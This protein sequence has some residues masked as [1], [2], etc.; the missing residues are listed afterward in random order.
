MVQGVRSQVPVLNGYSMQERDPFSAPRELANQAEQRSIEISEQNKSMID[1]VLGELE[2]EIGDDF[3][4]VFIAPGLEVAETTQAVALE[5]LSNSSKAIQTSR[6]IVE[7][8]EVAKSADS[9]TQFIPPPTRAAA[10][11]ALKK[12]RL[13]EMSERVPKK[14][15]KAKQSDPDPRVDILSGSTE[16]PAKEVNSIASLKEFLAPPKRA[17]ATSALEKMRLQEKDEDADSELSFSSSESDFEPSSVGSETESEASDSEPILE[18]ASRVK[19]AIQT[20]TKQSSPKPQRVHSAIEQ[21]REYL[22]SKDYRYTDGTPCIHK[23][24]TELG[25][26][27]GT[28][29]KM[30]ESLGKEVPKVLIGNIQIKARKIKDAKQREATDKEIVSLVN[31]AEYRDHKGGILF[32]KVAQKIGMRRSRLEKKVQTKLIDQVEEGIFGTNKTVLEAVQ[33]HEELNRK[34]LAY[35]N[36]VEYRY[37]NGGILYTTIAKKLGIPRST[38]ADK[39][40]YEL[41]SKINRNLNGIHPNL[42]DAIKQRK[43]DQ[44]EQKKQKMLRFINDPRYR[45]ENGWII[46]EKIAKEFGQKPKTVKDYALRYLNSEILEIKGTQKWSVKK[47][48]AKQKRNATLDQKLMEMMNDPKYRY[49]CGKISW[50]NISKALQKKGISF[51]KHVLQKRAQSKFQDKILDVRGTLQKIPPK[52]KKT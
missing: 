20:K 11:S 40:K 17:A 36:N 31:S 43:R 10:K 15:Q 47:S 21:V 52:R 3:E 18:V 28:V 35:V 49:T 12:M 41:K 2:F 45:F 34:I 48:K 32:N 4:E 7:S 13:Q 19:K 22:H 25:V 37:A 9:L 5:T 46:W 8:V 29:K 16:E 27:Y 1:L 33:E 6:S 26:G 42:I 24:R 38:L 51:T 23:I 14:I 50:S 44:K 39:V 30:I